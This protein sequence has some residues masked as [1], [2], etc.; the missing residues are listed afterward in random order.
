MTARCSG[1]IV[2]TTFASPAVTICDRW[3]EVVV[4]ENVTM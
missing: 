3:A 4:E 1:A 2:S